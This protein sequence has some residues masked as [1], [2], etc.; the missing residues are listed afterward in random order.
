ML[1]RPTKTASLIAALSASLLTV[2]RPGL[3]RA[4][5]SP[6]DG[7]LERDGASGSTR[8]APAVLEPLQPPLVRVPGPKPGRRWWVAGMLTAGG[9]NFFSAALGL[10]VIKKDA[11]GGWLV[12]PV[13]GPIVYAYTRT[14]EDEHWIVP[15]MLAG[16]QIAGIVMLVVGV[17]I[18]ASAR[19]DPEPLLAVGPLLA[20][21]ARGIAVAG[22][23]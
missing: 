3:S 4:D 16:F 12:V 1:A 7:P 21:A 22:R 17:A 14:V 13:A 10:E 6:P 5:D 8:P 19:E 11:A 18:A 9:F 2:W 15:A 20:R 23:F